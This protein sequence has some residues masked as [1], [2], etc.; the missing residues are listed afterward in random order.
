MK[1]IKTIVAAFGMIGF[2]L[3]SIGNQVIEADGELD[4]LKIAA[5]LQ[6]ENIMINEWS[7]HA[8][9]KM[10][11]LRNQKEI[12]EYTEELKAQFSDW[13][14][15]GNPFESVAVLEL[16]DVTETIKILSTPI[17]GQFETYV[18]YEAIGQ[19]WN[20][21]IEQTIGQKTADRISDIF[22][23][24][25]TT[26]SCIKGGFND[27][28]N[29]S[30]STEIQHLLTVFQAKEIESLNEDDFISSSAYSTM[31][32]DAVDIGEQDM[33]LQLGIRNQGLGGETT[34]VV[35]TP[36]ITIEY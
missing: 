16:A 35:G 28:M 20:Q 15:S 22:R 25:P 6:N 19:D 13:E 7:L 8:R 14:W 1:K 3:L 27:R 31:F 21:Q 10:E 33:N 5:I 11:S 36:I 29:R 9:E 24:N 12:S 2:I 18:I 30:L 32:S 4:L 34:L 17:N 26:F 23:G